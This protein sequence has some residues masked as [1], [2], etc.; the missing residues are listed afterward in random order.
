MP[1]ILKLILHS[2]R[3]IA[4]LLL[5]NVKQNSFAVKP[6]KQAANNGF[7]RFVAGGGGRAGRNDAISLAAGFAACFATNPPPHPA[8]I[9]RAV[10]QHRI[11]VHHK[12]SFR[13][14]SL[15]FNVQVTDLYPFSYF[16]WQ[17]IDT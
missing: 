5:C 4:G 7:E 1:F 2:T 15:K 8:P 6:Q 14:L 9:R 10:N 13:Q 12:G 3:K 11:A 17:N 16:F